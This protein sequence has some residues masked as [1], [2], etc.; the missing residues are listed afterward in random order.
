M[1]LGR[2]RRRISAYVLPRFFC[3]LSLCLALL[4]LS[5]TLLFQGS[6]GNFRAFLDC[7]EAG[8][9]LPWWLNGVL[10]YMPIGTLLTLDAMIALLNSLY[11]QW[12]SQPDNLLPVCKFQIISIIHFFR[13]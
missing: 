9:M 4:C 2:V 10:I 8:L 7:T 3:S 5:I 13:H 11:E 1:L 6:D 12:R